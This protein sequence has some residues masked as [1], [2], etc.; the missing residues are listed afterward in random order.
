MIP[1]EGAPEPT[2]LPPPPVA[3]VVKLAQ[4]V[5]IDRPCGT[6]FAFRSALAKTPQWRRGVLSA[7][8]DPPG[9]IWVGSRC[10]EIRTAPEDSTEQW[11]LEIT[12]YEP[13]SV[14]GIVARRGETEVRELHRFVREGDVTRYTVAV[15]VTG[16]SLSSSV[17]QKQL[18]ENLLQL[19]WAL[20]AVP[21]GGWGVRGQRR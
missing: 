15:E 5:I 4:T 2:P 11:E 14:L 21:A 17:F 18:L 1:L 8:L 13:A 10:T 19:K 20:E 9:P 6:V 3:K 12:Q 16:G 7:S